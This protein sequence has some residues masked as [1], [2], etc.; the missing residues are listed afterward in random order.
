MIPVALLHISAYACLDGC[1]AT[2]FRSIQKKFTNCF[3][4]K[5]ER[6]EP[7]A[8]VGKPLL[9]S[10]PTPYYA[11]TSST[12]S[13]LESE[14]SG[15]EVK[16][17]KRE[18]GDLE[19]IGF[20]KVKL[21]NINSGFGLRELQKGRYGTVYEMIPK[22]RT[23]KSRFVLKFIENSKKKSFTKEVFVNETSIL[24]Y[25]AD[26]GKG[27]LIARMINFGVS[28]YTNTYWIILELIRGRDLYTELDRFAKVSK[29]IPIEYLRKLLLQI[30]SAIREMHSLGLII[31]DLKPENIMV[32]EDGR[33]K[34]IDFGLS[35]FMPKDKSFIRNTTLSFCTDQ[36]IS[37]EMARQDRYSYSHDVWSF[38]VLL[39]VAATDVMPVKG[40]T[41]TATIKKIASLSK[42]KMRELRKDSAWLIKKRYGNCPSVY[43][44]IDLQRKLLCLDPE[45]RYKNFV[46]FHEHPFFAQPS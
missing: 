10:P 27:H 29:V 5:L 23:E 15:T 17:G 24:K 39:F 31:R 9:E 40:E 7:E 46:K 41:S 8:L 43:N 4:A 44:L 2:L 36:Y 22:D 6:G 12:L 1:G 18:N 32:D 3:V 26:N 25:I 14:L 45:K 35:T 34:L 11:S 13:S 16:E 19:G 20:G 28:K 42:H 37:P 30:A 21:C 33:V 38:G